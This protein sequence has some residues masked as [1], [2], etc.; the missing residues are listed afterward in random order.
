MISCDES[1]FNYKTVMNPDEPKMTQSGQKELYAALGAQGVIQ[2]RSSPFSHFPAFPCPLCSAASFL[3]K[4]RRLFCHR[5]FPSSF[6]RAGF[7]LLSP[8]LPLGLFFFIA[9]LVTYD[10]CHALDCMYTTKHPKM[11]Q[12]NADKGKRR[13]LDVT[14][15]LCVKS[16][17]L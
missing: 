4:N 12:G 6:S 9:G 2:P 7:L 3:R 8:L 11:K 5:R 17:H 10:L 16:V 13:A 15:N 14:P 1:T